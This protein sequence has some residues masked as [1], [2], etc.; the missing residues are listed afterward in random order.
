MPGLSPA[1][2]AAPSSTELP[3]RAGKDRVTFP[4]PGGYFPLG[5]CPSSRGPRGGKGLVMSKRL[6]PVVLLASLLL[7]SGA[8]AVASNPYGGGGMSG[9]GGGSGTPAA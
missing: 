3:P 4:S 1:R 6:G 2:R 5:S 7:G 9:G 8:V